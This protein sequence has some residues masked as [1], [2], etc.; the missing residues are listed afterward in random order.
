MKSCRPITGKCRTFFLQ[1]YRLSMTFPNN[2]EKT[3]GI[4]NYGCIRQL[5]LHA[6]EALELVWKTR[7]YLNRYS[8]WLPSAKHWVVRQKFGL[9]PKVGYSPSFITVLQ[10]LAD[11]NSS[12]YGHSE[13][14]NRMIR[15]ILNNSCPITTNVYLLVYPKPDYSKCLKD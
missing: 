2:Y 4:K 8:I 15:F 12:M 5:Y 6:S 9:T 14:P 3:Y 1:R 11:N 13:T 10:C 7:T